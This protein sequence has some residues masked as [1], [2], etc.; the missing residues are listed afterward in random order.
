[1]HIF[2]VLPKRNETQEFCCNDDMVKC[3]VANLKRP[4]LQQ[5]DEYVQLC[6]FD[7]SNHLCGIAKCLKQNKRMQQFWDCEIQSA[8]VVHSFK[9]ID[10]FPR[11]LLLLLYS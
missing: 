5:S 6:F 7:N 9:N 3:K 10:H 2:G 4:E 11:L 8:L 1:M